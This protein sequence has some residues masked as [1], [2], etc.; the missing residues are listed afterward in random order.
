MLGNKTLILHVG[1][2]YENKAKAIDNFIHNFNLLPNDLQSKIVLENDDK[3]YNVDE[4]LGICKTIGI[5]MCLDYHHD[6][7]LPSKKHI[8]DS[9]NRIKATWKGAVPKLHLSTGRY[10][11][12]DR[13]HADYV[14]ILDFDQVCAITSGKF[15][16]MLEAKAKDLAVLSLR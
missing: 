5:P 14:D 9:I 13:K 4:V 6:R 3:S 16:I 1:G 12:K 2:V 8:T 10:S 7:C 15:D 11:T